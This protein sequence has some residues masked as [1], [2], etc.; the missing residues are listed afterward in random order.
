MHIARSYFHAKDKIILITGYMS[1]I[2]K[3][4]LMFT[5][6]EQTTLRIGGRHYYLVFTTTCGAYLTISII[7]FILQRLFTILFSILID[8]FTQLLIISACSLLSK[9]FNPFL[10]VC[11]GFDVCSVNENRICVNIST[12]YN[13]LENMREDCFKNLTWEAMRKSIANRSKMRNL[14][15]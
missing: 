13:F 7:V 2:G 3:I 4:N 9:C 10:L 5:L 14:G 1:C 8:L 6:M 12:P 15:C 11:A